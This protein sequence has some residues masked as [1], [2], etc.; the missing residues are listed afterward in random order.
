MNSLGVEIGSNQHPELVNGTSQQG[1]GR[2]GRAPLGARYA[3]SHAASVEGLIKLLGVRST[4]TTAS[5][6][7]P[8]LAGAVSERKS[9]P[10]GVPDRALFR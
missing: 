5:A 10:F 3:D 9:A 1:L 8:A 6:F 2:T 7:L 4:V